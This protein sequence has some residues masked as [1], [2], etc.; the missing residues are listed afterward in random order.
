MESLKVLILYNEP[1]LETGHNDAA[2]EAGVLESVEAA[3]QALTGRGH[4]VKTLGLATS[5]RPLLLI[6]DAAT[7]DALMPIR[8]PDR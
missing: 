2:S 4:S 5:L 7:M 8:G 1:T 3:E 6:T